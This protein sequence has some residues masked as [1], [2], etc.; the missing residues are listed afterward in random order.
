MEDEKP[1]GLHCPGCGKRT[2]KTVDSRPVHGGQRRRRVCV[3]C[4]LKVI[5]M[6]TIIRTAQPG[7]GRLKT[8]AVVE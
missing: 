2:F 6:E 8:K 3:A 4:D 7:L 5:T 1:T